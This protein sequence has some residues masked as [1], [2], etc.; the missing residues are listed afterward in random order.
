[1]KKWLFVL[2]FVGLLG[3]GAA[4]W[5]SSAQPSLSV[6]LQVSDHPASLGPTKTIKVKKEQ[7]YQGNLV[8]INKTNPVHAAGKKSDVVKLSQQRDQAASYSLL[9]NTIRLSQS[10][11]GP[12]QTMLE[13]AEQEGVRH[14]MITSGY[15]DNE[16]QDKLY[17]EM[18]SGYALPAGYSE[19]NLGLGL[20]IGS[21]QG[22][23]SRA[24][25]GKWL[26]RNAAAYG[27]ILR[28]PKDKTAVTGIQFEPWHFRY[29]GLPH[30][31]VM[32]EKNMALEEYLDYL[33]EQKSYT[34][35]IGEQTYQ[36]SYYEVKGNASIP[37]P[38]N[39]R[40]ELSGN[41]R[42]GVIVTAAVGG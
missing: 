19:H 1:M 37:V 29:V 18:G 27:F 14:F 17:R 16:E 32:K 31:V 10:V 30:S 38:A 33:K 34:V 13:A 11:L 7:I 41:N 36:V 5:G 35:K 26:T 28:Y 4:N 6:D 3:Y 15:R 42:D 39:G 40:Y 12:L 22:E 25:E 23:M 24:A 8:L 20:D 9:D 2:I 21:T